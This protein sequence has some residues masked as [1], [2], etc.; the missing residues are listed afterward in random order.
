M[1]RA[2]QVSE[3]ERGRT[4]G[5]KLWNANITFCFAVFIISYAWE[6]EFDFQAGI[7]IYCFSDCI[8]SLLCGIKAYPLSSM[9][10]LRFATSLEEFLET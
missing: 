3:S 10:P 6:R 7:F 1:K 5:R 2:E 8:F 9:M 4:Q